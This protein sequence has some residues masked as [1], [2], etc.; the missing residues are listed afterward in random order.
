MGFENVLVL[1]FFVYQ[2]FL[3]FDNEWILLKNSIS[4]FSTQKYKS[5]NIYSSQSFHLQNTYWHFKKVI[6]VP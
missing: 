5:E 3:I 4:A 6:H 1:F 2:L